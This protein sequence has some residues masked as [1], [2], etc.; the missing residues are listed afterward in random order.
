M[1]IRLLSGLMTVV[2]VLG[3]LPAALAAAP[4]EKEAAQ[5]LAALDIMV[6]DSQG[7]LN[8]GRTITRAQFT[9]MTIAASASRDTVGDM[10]AVK[11]YPDVPQTHWA[12]PYIKAAVDLGLVQ[13]DLYG[14]FHP[15]EEITLAEGVTIVLRLLGYQGSEF[16]GMWPAGQMAQYRALGLHENITCG[17]NDSMSRQDA[18]WLFYNLLLTKNKGGSY[19]LNVLEPTLN[20]VNADGELDRVA[21]VNS[22]MEGPLVVGGS[23]WSSQL[24]FSVESASV[25]RN[26]NAVTSSSIQNQ[27]VVYW[28][29]SMHTVWAYSDKVTGILEDVQPTASAPTSVVVAGKTYPIETTEAAYLL[30]DLGEYQEGDSITLLL[31][32]DGGVVSTGTIAQDEALLYGVITKVE[33]VEYNEGSDTY[34]T[35]A[36]TIFATNGQTYRYQLSNRY[37]REGDIVQVIQGGDELEIKR[38]STNSKLSGKVDSKATR[39]GDHKL[40]AEVQILDTYESCTPIRIYASR[41]AGMEIT[42]N[43]VYF[44]ALNPQGEIS[45]LILKNATGD[46]H[47]YGVITQVMEVDAGMQVSSSYTYDY[48]GMQQV[49]GPSSAIYH[50][51]KGP[52]QIKMDSDA[53]VERL[54]NLSSQRLESISGDGQFA[55]GTNQRKYTLAQNVVVYLYQDDH[56]QI[57]SL[58][59]VSEGYTL[60][61]WYDKEEAQGGRIRVIIAQ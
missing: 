58:S 34:Q 12:A 39:I 46:L 16:T 33:N 24:P 45:H 22:A 9:K 56:Y 13:G 51:N 21:L 50:L 36:V 48:N 55:I 1:K 37:L 44:Y 28:S 54:Y 8:L 43:M 27:D 29:Q 42:Q 2:L 26:G 3:L 6:G 59:R 32:R 25:Y 60:T 47:R 20:L 15:D 49:F 40:A 57:S 31:G 35:R 23:G 18:L 61:G 30:S 7:N 38:L 10:V 5:T 41:L 4:T 53:T 11:P 17:Q 14:N 52:C 19:Y